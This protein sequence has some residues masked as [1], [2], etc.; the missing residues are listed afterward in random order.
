VSGSAGFGLQ[1]YFLE[2]TM[3]KMTLEQLRKLRGEK[4]TELEQRE[5]DGKTVQVI[6]G[7]G[8]CG[9]ASGAKDTLDAFISELKKRNLGSK[10][11]VRQA[12]CMGLCSHEPT[13]EIL[14]PDMPP[15]MY[16]DV[17]KDVVASIIESHIVN[18]KQLDSL[19]MA[20]RTNAV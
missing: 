8:T 11:I 2:R 6:V 9:I 3:A 5:S 7:M 12:A 20:Q 19:M 17:K 16:G 18:K 1:K 10:V 4:K 15:I 13:V 14:S